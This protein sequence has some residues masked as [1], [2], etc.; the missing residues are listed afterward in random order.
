MA[1]QTESQQPIGKPK[2]HP[3]YDYVNSYPISSINTE[4]D[5]KVRRTDGAVALGFPYVGWVIPQRREDGSNIM[6]HSASPEDAARI[7]RQLLVMAGVKEVP[8]LDKILA[9]EEP[10]IR[11]MLSDLSKYRIPR[12]AEQVS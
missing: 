1:Y 3:G 12:S 11:S 9:A 7:L 4:F 5:L 10:L 6:R 2:G 8:P